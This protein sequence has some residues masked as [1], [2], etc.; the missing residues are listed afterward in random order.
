MLQ[1]RVSSMSLLK[2]NSEYLNTNY[3][4]KTLSAKF[5]NLLLS[6]HDKFGLIINKSSDYHWFLVFFCPVLRF[7]V[8][9]HSQNF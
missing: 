7:A 5:R 3:L 6:S 2:T 8:I 1:T 9:L 4:P